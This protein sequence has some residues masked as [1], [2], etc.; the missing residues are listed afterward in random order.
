M[1][2]MLEGKEIDNLDFLLGQSLYSS[3]GF[4]QDGVQNTCLEVF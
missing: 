4:I 1:F 3:G 2:H